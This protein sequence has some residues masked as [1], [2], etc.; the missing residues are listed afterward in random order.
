MAV[1]VCDHGEPAVAAGNA[2]PAGEKPSVT[3]ATFTFTVAGAEDPQLLLAMYVKL[4]APENPG[5][6]V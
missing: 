2:P 4:S 6:G 5:A 1:M 3:L